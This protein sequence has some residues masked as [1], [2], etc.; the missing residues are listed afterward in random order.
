[1]MLC[2]GGDTDAFLQAEVAMAGLF[3]ARDMPVGPIDR[4]FARLS[5]VAVH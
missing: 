4:M 3:P 1:M 5:G 2:E